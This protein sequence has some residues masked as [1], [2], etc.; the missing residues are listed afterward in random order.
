M[1]EALRRAGAD[2]RYTEY[3]DAGH[4]C[5]DRAYGEPELWKWLLEQ[6]RR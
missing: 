6:R 1:A 3:P 2:V 4:D 5:W